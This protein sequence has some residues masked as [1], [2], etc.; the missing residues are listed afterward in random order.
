MTIVFGRIVAL[1]EPTANA[2]TH[3]KIH[4]KILMAGDKKCIIDFRMKSSLFKGSAPRLII[5]NYCS[6]GSLFLAHTID[7]RCE[8]R[9][10]I[11]HI[12]WVIE[13]VPLM[14]TI[15]LNRHIHSVNTRTQRRSALI[16]IPIHCD[17]RIKLPDKFSWI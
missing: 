9:L 11:F 8:T 15:A 3:W 5:R 2:Y 7:R 6:D 14:V 4:T 1:F 16:S 13:K 17:D 12:N 10:P